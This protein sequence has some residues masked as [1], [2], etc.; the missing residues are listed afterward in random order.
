MN[1]RNRLFLRKTMMPSEAA[2]S[3][4]T[5]LSTKAGRWM[6]ESPSLKRVKPV[7][8]S[9]STIEQS[10]TLYFAIAL[11]F[12]ELFVIFYVISLSVVLHRAKFQG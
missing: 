4:K 6:E 9:R 2:S 10:K 3:H 11:Q 1:W 8:L 7:C 12:K 5:L